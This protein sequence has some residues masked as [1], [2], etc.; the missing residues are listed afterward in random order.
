MNYINL[1]NKKKLIHIARKYKLEY[2]DKTTKIKSILIEKFSKIKSNEEVK[3]LLEILQS[4]SKNNMLVP[5]YIKEI[6][7][8]NQSKSITID[9]KNFNNYDNFIELM[10][11]DFMEIFDNRKPKMRSYVAGGYGAKLLLS[12]KYDIDKINTPDL[13]ITLSTKG[14]SYNPQQLQNYIVKRCKLFINNQHD[15]ENYKLNV[16]KFPKNYNELFKMQRYYVVSIYYNDKDFID[17][18]ITDKN[19]KSNHLEKDISKKVGL[20]IK[21]VDFYLQ[22]FFKMLYMETVP[23]VDNYA[24]LKRNPT[25]G[26]FYKKGIKDINRISL[27]CSVNDNKK[28][29]KFCDLIKKITKDDKISIN[30]FRKMEKSE[31]DSYFKSLKFLP[32]SSKNI[33][34]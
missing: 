2:G 18:A 23:G 7:L 22:D 25:T 17:L 32:S 27:L 31:R 9:S 4:V 5:K 28:Y 20:C 19:I 10:K 8:V 24:Y 3:K 12:E 30:N 16:I 15:S 21:K 14:C 33:S 1:L 26:K 13:D 11:D 34:F 6:K 29:D